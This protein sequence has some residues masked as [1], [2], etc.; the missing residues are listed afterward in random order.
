VIERV[1]AASG[2][3]YSI[4]LYDREGGEACLVDPVAI[5]S[6][7]QVIKEKNLDPVYLVNTHGH[8][9]HT[10]GN[11]RF[12]RMADEVVGH[13]NERGSIDGLTKTVTDQDALTVGDLTIEV[14]HTPGHTDGS[15]C[16]KTDN[17][18]ISGDTVFLAGC[19]NPSFGGNTRELFRSFRDKLV[20]LNDDLELHPGH[21]YAERNLRFA[22]SVDPDNPAIDEKLNEAQGNGEPTSTLGDEKSYNPF[23][24]YDD[25]DLIDNLDGL[26]EAP[27]NWDVFRRLRELRNQ[28]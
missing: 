25:P 14:L 20:H 1:R 12:A 4:V 5:Q 10:A 15:I 19:G 18:L 9:D 11:Q 23:F 21:D 27:S 7:S 2:D 24:R 13:E 8:G 17:A 6:V 3:N 26:P 22:K 28:W 16:L